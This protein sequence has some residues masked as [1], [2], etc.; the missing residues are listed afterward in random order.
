MPNRPCLEISNLKKLLSLTSSS[1]ATLSNI[2]TQFSGKFDCK[3]MNDA[4]KQQAKH[5][6]SEL[7][8]E[9]LIV[10]IPKARGVYLF[11]PYILQTLF[12]HHVKY[13]G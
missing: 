2:L 9:K 10:K 8:K 11:S 13:N 3:N 1:R 7:I 6:M 12:N 5:G 4:Q